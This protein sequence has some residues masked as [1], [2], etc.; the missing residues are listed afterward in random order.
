MVCFILL[1]IRKGA[2]Y[3]PFV[4][5]P[6]KIRNTVSLVLFTSSLLFLVAC[7]HLQRKAFNE[8]VFSNQVYAS[9]L[10]KGGENVSLNSSLYREQPSP[11]NNYCGENVANGMPER[12]EVPALTG[13]KHNYFITHKV[14]G[15]INYSVEFDTQLRTPRF[16][17]FTF[18]N[19]NYAKIAKRS[20]AWGSNPFVPDRVNPKKSDF[21]GYDRGHLVAS[22]DRVYSEAANKQTFYYTNMVLQSHSHNAGIWKS[23]ED[24]VQCWAR[25][26]SMAI[27]NKVMYVAKGVTC[28]RQLNETFVMGYGVTGIPVARYFWM[29]VIY[30]NGD[31]DCF[32][33]AFLTDHGKPKTLRPLRKYALS[34]DELE[35]FIAKDLFPN[36]PDSIEH[37]VERQNPLEYV[38]IWRGI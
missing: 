23:L 2:F 32:G 36:F 18:D 20:S 9:S 3:F 31:G 35:A 13:G 25:V 38:H 21:E 14:K 28:D 8:S 29:A 22:N 24:L 26:Y 4:F 10:E 6:M 7:K 15:Q 34:I 5:C 19:S 1:A 30:S 11:D 37:L 12:L 17:A 33:I 27:G 16:V